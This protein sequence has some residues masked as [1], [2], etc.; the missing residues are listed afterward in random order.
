MP[1]KQNKPRILYPPRVSNLEGSN[2]V[3]SVAFEKNR[4]VLSAPPTSQVY[5]MAL[6]TSARNTTKSI[7]DEIRR[8]LS[9]IKKKEDLINQLNDEKVEL[10]IQY[11]ELKAAR[12]RSQSRAL[13]SECDW[14]KGEIVILV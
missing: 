1:A 5:G 8:V 2:S 4:L 9:E 13:A 6:D 12:L 10:S 7:D 14:E 3:N 11:E